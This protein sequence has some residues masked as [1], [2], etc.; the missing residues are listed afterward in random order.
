MNIPDNMRNRVG[1][2]NIVVKKHEDGRYMAQAQGSNLPPV[3]AKDSQT[4]IQQ[5]TQKID[6]AMRTSTM[7]GF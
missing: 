5:M 1:S 4:A 7:P 6:E 2:F 3:W